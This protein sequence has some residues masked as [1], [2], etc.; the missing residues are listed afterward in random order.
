MNELVIWSSYDSSDSP[1]ITPKSISEILFCFLK[2]FLESYHE[3]NIQ[4]L[5]LDLKDVAVISS[6][7]ASKHKIS[8]IKD[9]LPYNGDH[10]QKLTSGLNRFFSISKDQWNR[11]PSTPLT[12]LR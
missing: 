11:V 8:N 5:F 4:T 6:L 3:K 7:T 12:F 1:V 10:M 2:D 9:F